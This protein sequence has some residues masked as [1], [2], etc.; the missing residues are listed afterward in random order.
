MAREVE[1]EF[2]HDN[3]RVTKAAESSRPSTLGKRPLSPETN[4]QT[5]NPTMNHKAEM[6]DKDSF[7][8]PAS[9]QSMPE[10]LPPQQ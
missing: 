2:G 6:D 7:K 1:M 10:L 3:K 8:L 5:A 4:I 9:G